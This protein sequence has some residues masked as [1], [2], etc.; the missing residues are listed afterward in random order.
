MQSDEYDKNTLHLILKGLGI[1][2]SQFYNNE[3]IDKV[4]EPKDN[5][6]PIKKASNLEYLVGKLQEVELSKEKKEK[7]ILTLL[8]KFEDRLREDVSFSDETASDLKAIVQEIK[9]CYD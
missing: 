2:E 3:V 4:S 5:Y 6:R 1:T 8:D 9:K 7:M